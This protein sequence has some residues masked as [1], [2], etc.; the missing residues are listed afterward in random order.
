MLPHPSNRSSRNTS[1]QDGYND[2]SISSQSPPSI[3]DDVG[4][5]LIDTQEVDPE[6]NFQPSAEARLGSK[7]PD[8][9][10]A[11]FDE[12]GAELGP[13]ARIWPAYVKEAEMW[14]EE[15]VDGWNSFVVESFKN[16]QPDPSQTS[17]N[18]LLE[19]T[20][21][22]RAMS[23]GSNAAFVDTNSDPSAFSPPAS[24]IWINALWFLSLALSV[25]VSLVVML[26]KQW[27]YSYM[28]G[29]LGQPCV[30]ARARQR[31]LEELERWR[32]PEILAF[33]PTL[34]H[35]SLFLFFVGLVINL[36]DAHVG[37]AAPV[38]ATTAT[39]VIFYSLTTVLPVAYELCP[40][41]TPLSK[42]LKASPENIKWLRATVTHNC[43][44]AA[45][46]VASPRGLVA[47]VHSGLRFIF[48][49]KRQRRHGQGGE[50]NATPGKPNSDSTM[51]HLTSRALSWLLN[52]SQDTRS[53]DTALQAIA[54]ADYRLPTK[55]LLECDA[56]TLLAQRFRG[57]FVSHPQSGFSFLVNPGS[58][59]V[60]SL[61]GRALEFFMKDRKHVDVVDHV[62]RQG[63]GGG[64]AVR[65]A[66]QCLQ[67]DLGR[68]RPNL[69]AFGLSGVSTWWSMR[70]HTGQIPPGILK[71]ALGMLDRHITSEC[72]LHPV[73]L[74]AVIDKISA[75]AQFWMR[76]LTP[77]ERALYP[78]ALIRLLNQLDQ[79]SLGRARPAIATCLASF[80]FI[81]TRS[82]PPEFNPGLHASQ[83][84][85]FMF[86][87]Y[88][89]LD[90]ARARDAEPLLVYGLLS[91]LRDREAY[92]L[93]DAE[94]SVIVRQLSLVYHLRPPPSGVS[95]VFIPPP[96]NLNTVAIQ[97]LLSMLSADIRQTLTPNTSADLLRALMP[98]S[99]MW[100]NKSNAIYAIVAETFRQPDAGPSKLAWDD[101]LNSGWTPYYTAD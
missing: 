91:L 83:S 58:A 35:L 16:L 22:L 20:Q 19:I 86:L 47:N 65:R 3:Q 59:D 38:I 64:F 13:D 97:T 57:C 17:A 96:S 66:Y 12:Y 95:F 78:L 41:N 92:E 68:T 9:P 51:D 28:S 29:R 100:G 21:L 49:G 50:H 1:S 62:L 54:G 77:R 18:A 63:P 94:I 73:G 53:V 11:G 27:C 69:A 72:A 8:A 6:P 82:F 15:M 30:Q 5:T 89:A 44:Q 48:F 32:M 46:Q 75:E 42:F 90:D 61:Y 52:N 2:Q 39:T 7:R 33:L 37:V 99:Y 70:S 60:A 34:I 43:V 45:K 81:F 101:W 25:S 55:P 24:A 80:A 67:Y 10:R 93:D 31:R 26:A 23:N 85:G 40:Y 4:E 84:P 14:D 87:H 88:Y 74:V 98:Y 56:H 76:R 36:W 71:E 79:V